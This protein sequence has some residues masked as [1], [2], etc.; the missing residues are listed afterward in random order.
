M[1]SVIRAL[2]GGALV[3]AAV[4]ACGDTLVDGAYSGTPRFTLQ[5]KVMG[6]SDNVNAFDFDHAPMRTSQTF[7][8]PAG[9]LAETA[10]AGGGPLS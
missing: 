3:G 9:R 10:G 6:D 2:V 5:G 8:S 7:M 1:A 4:T